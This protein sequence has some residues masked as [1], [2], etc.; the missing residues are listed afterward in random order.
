MPYT[1]KQ[2]LNL[3]GTGLAAVGH[4]SLPVS[5]GYSGGAT[6]TRARSVPTLPPLPSARAAFGGNVA[7]FTQAPTNTLNKRNRCRW[8]P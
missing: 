3:P 5:G 4:C 7:A 1:I 6:I 8:Q 2:L